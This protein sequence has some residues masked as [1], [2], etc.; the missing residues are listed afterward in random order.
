LPHPARSPQTHFPS[1]ERLG[2]IVD[3]AP[4]AI[5]TFDA[6]GLVETWNTEAERIFDRLRNDAVGQT[7]A[8]LGAD[9]RLSEIAERVKRGERISNEPLTV[10]RGEE[11]LALE[12]SAS[13]VAENRGIVAVISDVTDRNRTDRML[14]ELNTE[15]ERRV[16]ERTADLE[17][18]NKELEAFC[19]SVSHDLRAPLR[20]IDGFSRAVLQE[21]DAVLTN[22]SKNHLAR[23]R[24]A[25]RRMSELIDS[26]LSLSRLTRVQI[27]REWVNLSDIAQEIVEDLEYSNPEQNNRFEIQPGIKAYGD[28]RLLRVLMD[29]L[30]GNAFKFSANSSGALITFGEDDRGIFVQDEGAGFDMQYVHRLFNP[31]ERLHSDKEYSGNGIG[32][33]TAQRIVSRH[34]GEIVAEGALGKGA[35]FTFKLSSG[36]DR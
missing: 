20:A 23:V 3:C 6:H 31:F 2:A 11:E 19:F 34:G 1:L 26:L 17:A 27:K 35:R 21:S 12:V 14:K 13:P 29:N 32:L 15:L 18:A 25:S 5:I 22:A 7:L 9:Q 36:P 30:L 8:N 33:A 16:S 4:I 28:P 24:K 10:K